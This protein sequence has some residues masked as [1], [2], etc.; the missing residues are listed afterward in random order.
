MRDF[1]IS[2]VYLYSK[3]DEVACIARNVSQLKALSNVYPIDI[4]IVIDSSKGVTLEPIEKLVSLDNVSII[5]RPFSKTFRE[6]KDWITKNVG[7]NQYLFLGDG[8]ESLPHLNELYPA[9]MRTMN[10]NHS[11]ND[12]E[13]IAFARNNAIRWESGGSIRYKTILDAQKQLEAFKDSHRDGEQDVPLVVQSGK[14]FIY[15]DNYCFPDYQVRLINKV[16]FTGYRGD[17]HAV[18]DTKNGFRYAMPISRCS[19]LSHVKTFDRFAEGTELYLKM[20][21]GGGS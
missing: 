1:P 19:I 8:D 11:I 4:S 10:D 7:N 5:S 6:H 13:G 18:P 12:N 21:P 20:C 3:E 14:E 9:L 16:S 17:Y 15:V 2:W